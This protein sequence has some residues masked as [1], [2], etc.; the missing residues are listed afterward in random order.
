M[1]DTERVAMHAGSL[2]QA[3][4]YRF[5]TRGQPG[6]RTTTPPRQRV[7]AQ[8]SSRRAREGA[9]PSAVAADWRALCAPVFRH[10]VLTNFHA[11]S[12]RVT[13]DDLVERLLDDVRPP[14]SG[15]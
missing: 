5:A 7:A 10:R 3:R 1:R 13:S 9:Y 2:A 8:A 12:E 14:S 11:E 15:M 6:A 4:G